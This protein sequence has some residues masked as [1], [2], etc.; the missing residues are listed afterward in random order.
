[1]SYN[2]DWRIKTRHFEINIDIDKC[3]GY[4][5]HDEEGEDWG[6]GL[7]FSP[8]DDTLELVDYGGMFEL[9]REVESALKSFGVIIE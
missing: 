9:P 2:F 5:K 6:V 8:I 7:W 3:Y 1:M 4:F